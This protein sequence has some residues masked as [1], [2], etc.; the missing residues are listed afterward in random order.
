MV[1]PAPV[2]VP[3]QLDRVVV[4]RL[5]DR[6]LRVTTPALPGW[7]CAAPPRE[8]LQCLDAAWTE[9]QIAAY[10]AR[11]GQPYDAAHHAEPAQPQAP[12]QGRR[13]PER[14]NPADWTPLPG[15]D[16]R[17]PSGRTY[18]RTAAVV[19]RVV[20]RRTALG[21]PVTPPDVEETA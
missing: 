7:A 13:Y 6:R 12:V 19:E 18:R 9:L 15:G 3:V 5:P 14:Y 1:E 16:W 10:A 2:R 17:S 8:L 20:R 11:Q 21:L 4:E